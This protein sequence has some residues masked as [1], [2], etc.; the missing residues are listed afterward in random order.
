MKLGKNYVDFVFFL[1]M[2]V[3]WVPTFEPKSIFIVYLVTAATIL[4]THVL[5]FNLI[6]LF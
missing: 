2:F 3:T 5:F 4:N 1:W 6:K